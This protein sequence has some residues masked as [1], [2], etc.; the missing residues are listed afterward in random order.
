MPLSNSEALQ[1]LFAR[2]TTREQSCEDDTLLV[3]LSIYAKMLEL[4]TVES[5]A[6]AKQQRE[7]DEQ[8]QR[9]RRKE[10]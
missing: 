7:P 6:A 8:N 3:A 4:D 10:V 5:T 2:L 9:T 1:Q